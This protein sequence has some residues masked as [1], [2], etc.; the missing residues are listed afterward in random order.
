MKQL[1]KKEF[2]AFCNKVLPVAT[3]QQMKA[4]LKQLAKQANEESRK[5]AI[6]DPLSKIPRA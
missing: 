4:G 3:P 2:E 5:Q 1:S 6:L